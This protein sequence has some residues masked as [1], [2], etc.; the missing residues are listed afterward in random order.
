VSEESFGRESRA[1][2]YGPLEKERQG[3]TKTE[4][5]TYGHTGVRRTLSRAELSMTQLLHLLLL[6]RSAVGICTESPIGPRL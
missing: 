4:C 2:S 1:Q 6:T 5:A 3:E